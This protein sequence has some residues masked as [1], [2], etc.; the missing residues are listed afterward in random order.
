MESTNWE[1]IEQLN[2]ISTYAY[3]Y[4]NLTICVVGN[5]G[6]LLSAFVFLQKT[7]RKNVCV[8][9]LLIDL[10]LSTIYLNTSILI[11]TLILGFD[12]NRLLSH[13]IVCKLFFYT[14]LWTVML[15]P[16]VLV[17][18]A[19]DR[20]L[21]S[22]QNVDTRLYSSRRLAYFSVGIATGFW[23]LFSLHALI[24]VDIQHFGPSISFCYY[25]L[26]KSYQ[27][28][29]SFS[30]MLF[31]T[32]FCF[33]LLVLSAISFKNV[34]QIRSIPRQQRTRIRAMNK[35]DFQLLRCLFTHVI[36]Y[37]ICSAFPSSY[38]IYSI[39][40]LYQH[41]T[42]LQQT[43]DGVVMNIFNL[44]YFTYHGTSIFVFI[45]ISKAFRNELKRYIYKVIGKE[46]ITTRTED[47]QQHQQQQSEPTA[48]VVE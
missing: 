11:T 23:L 34:R 36:V 43:L 18:A 27:Q 31:N 10:L 38:S 17:L 44:L 26:E 37:I 22:S 15:T 7:W 28:F 16:T 9:Y 1:A 32:V 39:A 42:L 6:N 46:L 3:R 29:I 13:T 2:R 8:F 48:N 19:I 33:T 24:K 4:G 40:T 30:L 5:I 41:R 20:L 47:Q 45:A 12:I 35:K 21:L 14:S 25:D